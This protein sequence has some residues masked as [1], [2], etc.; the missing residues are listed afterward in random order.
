MAM[1]RGVVVAKGLRVGVAL[2][3][4]SLACSAKP[5]G[6]GSP[7]VGGGGG[8]GGD[9]GDLGGGGGFGGGGGDLGGGGGGGFG[10]GGGDLGGGGGG[11]FG[12]GGGDLGG[13]G[14]GGFGGGLGGDGGDLGGTG[15][16]G[17]LG[18]G[19][20]GGITA[21]PLVLPS[22][23]SNL[24]SA[25]PFVAPC[26]Y[27]GSD[28]GQETE[29]CF[30]AGAD[31]GT[32]AAGGVRVTV[33]PLTQPQFDCATAWVVTVTKADGS[34]CYSFEDHEPTQDDCTTHTWTWKDAS[35]RVVANGSDG[36]QSSPTRSKQ[37]ICA[38]GETATCMQVSQGGQVS[39][40][41][42]VGVAGSASCP[43]GVNPLVCTAGACP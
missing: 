10:G 27:S 26:V 37:I 19:G 15:F 33:T 2:A 31:G 38:G 3:L 14:G 32:G 23:V 43:D 12:G 25:C 6:G 35:G 17:D 42:G 16:G 1:N 11:G 13:G 40:C 8:P 4:M 7:G 24:L 36:I 41:C 20:G 18:V 29:Y 21:T 28:A 9:G 22:C 5:L 39:S 30:A 34:P